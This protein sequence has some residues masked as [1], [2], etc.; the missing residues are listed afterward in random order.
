MSRT[1]SPTNMMIPELVSTLK[2]F[3]NKEVGYNIFQRFFHDH[4][5]RNKYDYEQIWKY[6]D[7][8]P[9]HWQTDCFFVE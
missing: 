2:R 1:P 6:I 3:V 7:A 8:N 5:I 4:I 9:S